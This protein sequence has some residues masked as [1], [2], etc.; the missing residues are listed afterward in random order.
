MSFLEIVE[1]KQYQ[2]LTF[3]NKTNPDFL[4]DCMIKQAWSLR[5]FTIH[6][7]VAPRVVTKGLNVSMQMLTSLFVDL[8]LMLNGL[9]SLPNDP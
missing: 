2:L 5:G 7:F 6:R 9:G 4:L 1:S 8:S 3:F